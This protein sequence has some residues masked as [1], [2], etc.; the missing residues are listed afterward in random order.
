MRLKVQI[1]VDLAYLKAQMEAILATAAVKSQDG[2]PKKG[3][4]S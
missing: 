2:A 1:Y 3:D 4:V